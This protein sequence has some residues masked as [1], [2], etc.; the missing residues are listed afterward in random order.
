M[1]VMAEGV[2]GLLRMRSDS[3]VVWA[4]RMEAES[5]RR[6]SGFGGS[7]TSSV[8]GERLWRAVWKFF[9]RAVVDARLARRA[10]RPSE[11]PEGAILGSCF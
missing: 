3:L 10:E 11:Y 8:D 6:R 5:E 9:T 2:K 4:F 1:K 7:G